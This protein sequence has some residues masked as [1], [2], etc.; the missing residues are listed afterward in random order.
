MMQADQP[1][2]VFNCICKHGPVLT[3]NVTLLN[4]LMIYLFLFVL[5]LLIVMY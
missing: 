3:R 5:T 1:L 4:V 2:T